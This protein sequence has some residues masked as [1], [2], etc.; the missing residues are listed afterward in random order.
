MLSSTA[1][2][3]P[4]VVTLKSQYVTY[5]QHKSL[6]LLNITIHRNFS[7]KGTAEGKKGWIHL[8]KYNHMSFRLCLRRRR[9]AVDTSHRLPLRRFWASR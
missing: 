4:A 2:F 6:V 5:F 7:E 3:C 9:G 1:H 8:V